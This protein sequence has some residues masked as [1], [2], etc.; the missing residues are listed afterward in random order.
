M[1]DGRFAPS[2]TGPLHL[3]NL[4]TA[5]LAWLFARHD[6]SR[7][8]LRIEDLDAVASRPEHEASALADMAALGLDHDGPIVRQ[9][10]RHEH[11]EAAIARLVAEDRTYPCY[12]TRREVRAELEASV[13][14]PHG[15]LP[16][17]AYPGTCARLD[18]AGRAEREAGGRRPSLRVRAEAAEASFHDR[19]HGPGRGVVDDFVVRRADGAP[20]YNLAVVVD[21]ADQGIGEVVRGD[22]LLDSTPRQILLGRWL[23]L[24]EPTYAHVPLVLGPDGERLA[25]RH[26]SVTLTDQRAAGRTPGRVLA[27]MG[28]SL[29]LAEPHEAVDAPTLLARFDPDRL[30]RDP[31]ALPDEMVHPI[32]GSTKNG[33]PPTS[34][35]RTA[36]VADA[37][38]TAVGTI[39]EGHRP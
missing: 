16:A 36:P 29:G 6:G 27:A 20:A 39:P 38:D 10:E 37:G 1:P 28:A 26:G 5:L 15:P 9:S 22:D 2:P 18:R 13:S 12:C 30:P 19:I 4:R 17:D 31:W 32:S 21:D 23:G 7:F 24:P 25:K 3:G 33:T 8:L 11:Y 35:G 34:G 14:A